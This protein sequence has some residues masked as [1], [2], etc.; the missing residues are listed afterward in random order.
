MFKALF[1]ERYLILTVS[2]RPLHFRLSLGLLYCLDPG[3]VLGARYAAYVPF[4]VSLPFSDLVC[5]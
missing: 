3:F 2:N 1:S 5:D 4:N